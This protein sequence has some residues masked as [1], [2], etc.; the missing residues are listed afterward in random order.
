MNKWGL[1]LFLTLSACGTIGNRDG[2][3]EKPKLSDNILQ[4]SGKGRFKANEPVNEWWKNWQDKDL[5][6]LIKSAFADN[7]DINIAINRVEESRSILRDKQFDYL[8]TPNAS[9]GF[10]QQRLSKEGISPVTDRSVRTYTAGFD[11]KWEL[12][13]FG[14]ISEGVKAQRA[15]LESSKADLAG[16]YVSVAA[17]IASTY[18]NLRG[19][20]YR[21]DIAKKNIAI[22]S[23]TFDLTKNLFDAGKSNALDLARSQAQL[24][25]TK[26][27]LPLLQA[28][29]TANINRLSV[30]TG[31]T[32]DTLRQSL[33]ITK[34]MPSLPSTVSIG[35]VQDLIK[36][37]PDIISAES[38]FMAASA[39]YNI[40]TTDMYPQVNL[41]GGIGFL[42]TDFD[43][44]GTGGTSTMFFAPEIRWPIFDLGHMQSRIDAADAVT[45]Q[46]LSFFNK[47][48]LNAL[49]ETDTAMVRFTREE[50][51][52]Q[53]LYIAANANAS[54]T[55]MADERYQ[56]GLDSFLDVLTAQQ[57]QFESE[58]ELAQSDIKSAL[59]LI[60]VYKALGG[61]WQ[62]SHMETIK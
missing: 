39:K 2:I 19:A 17:E 45:K 50:E 4:E 18:I 12:D 23:K 38:D 32:P 14:R 33:S 21:Y 27:I 41:T 25:T 52:R 58:D 35:N 22:Q 60:S 9:A 51:R 3:I 11:A 44:L 43:S 47:V 31:K 28:D 42:S 8:P 56:A 36:R 6:E 48:L 13:L 16:A 46:K 57:K 61:G 37:R 40:A 20:Q 10:N 5:N 49:E 62:F 54:A 15:E 1:F 53:N 59:S 24:E 7:P 55:K 34:K 30:L 26:A 29:I